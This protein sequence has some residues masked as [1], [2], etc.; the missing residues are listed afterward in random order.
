MLL[1]SS[2]GHSRAMVITGAFVSDV[3]RRLSQAEMRGEQVSLTRSFQVG[4]RRFFPNLALR[5]LRRS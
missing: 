2:A 3:M 1:L 5:S 4:L